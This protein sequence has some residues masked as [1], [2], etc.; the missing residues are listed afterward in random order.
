M[1]EQGKYEVSF[2]GTFSESQFSVGDHNLLQQRVGEA[3]RERLEPAEV[4]ALARDLRDIRDR[5][6]AQTPPD[7][8]DEALSRVGELEATTMG[9]DHPE[10]ARIA[11]VYRWFLRNAPDIAESVSTLLLGP[12]VGKLVGGGTGA[13]AAAVGAEDE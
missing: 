9:A 5:T 13:I 4:E 6:A 10:P 2:S 11:R 1:S 3:A 8:R 7:R 12:L